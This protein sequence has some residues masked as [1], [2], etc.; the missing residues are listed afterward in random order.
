MEEEQLT[1]KQKKELHK[2]ESHILLADKKI[3][4]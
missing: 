3:I 1:K 2:A 4:L